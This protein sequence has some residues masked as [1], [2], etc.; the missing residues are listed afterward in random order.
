MANQTIEEFAT[1]LKIPS[2]VHFTRV[3][4]LQSILKHGLYSVARIHEIGVEPV[5]NDQF[6]LD[7]RLDA[8]SV[9]IAFPNCQMMYKYRRDDE[10]VDWVVLLL[11]PSI[12][13]LKK[14]AFCRHN[15]ADGRIS[16]LP[17]EALV[18]EEAFRGM[19][20]E[21][22]GH[23]PRDEQRLHSFDPTDVQAE[24]L[25]LDRI[26]PCLITGAVFASKRA[27]DAHS[28]SLGAERKVELHPGNKGMFGSRSYS[29]LYC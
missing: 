8:V 7:G 11:D 26:E 25:V 28:P 27:K 10:T 1:E 2:L 21:L 13:W 16:K 15:A 29:R 19:F 3:V 18:T 24:V 20:E 4:N 22:E 12:L 17:L 5:I 14:C 9:S 6:R 23:A